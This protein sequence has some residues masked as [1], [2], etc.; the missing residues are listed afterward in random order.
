V[1]FCQPG[2]VWGGPGLKKLNVTGSKFS[3]PPPPCSP[4]A[5]DSGHPWTIL[6]LQSLSYPT[7]HQ[8]C[9]TYLRNVWGPRT[10]FRDTVLPP[11]KK[12]LLGGNVSGISRK[13]PRTL[14]NLANAGTASLA[15]L[16]LHDCFT[17]SFFCISCTECLY[18]PLII[19][20]TDKL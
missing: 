2:G 14:V 13:G 15:T 12:L 5:C 8:G 7:G 6:I 20:R 11:G 19:V 18:P 10:S 3:V 1:A 17:F 9:S 4:C 16:L